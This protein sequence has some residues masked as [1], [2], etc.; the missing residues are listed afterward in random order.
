MNIKTIP[1]RYTDIFKETGEVGLPGD[2]EFWYRVSNHITSN[3]LKSKFINKLTCR[4]D[5]EGYEL[6]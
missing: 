1:L 5:E 3:N 6:Q 2:A 4:H